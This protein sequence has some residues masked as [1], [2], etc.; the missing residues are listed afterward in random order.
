[1][2]HFF[3]RGGNLIY[4][5]PNFLL[6]KQLPGAADLTHMLHE[7]GLLSPLQGDVP[8]SVSGKPGQEG[9]SC[10]L[11][12]LPKISS[13]LTNWNQSL[14]TFFPSKA[15]QSQFQKAVASW[16]GTHLWDDLFLL[17][18]AGLSVP[19]EILAEVLSPPRQC[20]H[21]IGCQFLEA[22]FPWCIL[23]CAVRMAVMG[24]F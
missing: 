9:S 22:G 19:I 1:M 3:N 17:G 2:I 23:H 20:K 18:G 11:T 5:S 21:S 12:F 13:H 6:R 16:S 24:Q 15:L 10:S 8:W 7:P 14:Q 4:S